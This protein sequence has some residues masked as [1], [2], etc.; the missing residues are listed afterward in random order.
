M[1]LPIN[2]DD[3]PSSTGTLAVLDLCNFEV[4]IKATPQ[5]GRYISAG[6]VEWVDDWLK[7]LNL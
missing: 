5:S 6:A 4:V 7:Y 1:Y 2:G 3:M